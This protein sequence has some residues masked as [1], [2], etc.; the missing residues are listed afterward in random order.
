MSVSSQKLPFWLSS[1]ALKLLAESLPSCKG[2][3]GQF[4]QWQ[5]SLWNI[6]HLAFAEATWSSVH[7]HIKHYTLAEA[8]HGDAAFGSY[9]SILA[10]LRTPRVLLQV[11]VSCSSSQSPTEWVNIQRTTSKIFII[12]PSI[13][14]F[15]SKSCLI[16]CMFE[17]ELKR[18]DKL[19]PVF[20][21]NFQGGE[22]QYIKYR[23]FPIVLTG[24]YWLVLVT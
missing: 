4:E 16:C 18:R 20:I 22:H 15:L 13:S 10:Q 3:L 1:H 21:A 17:E 14:L 9:P 23:C 11:I 8:F 7:T 6:A 5:P 12:L 19:S 2:S 24:A